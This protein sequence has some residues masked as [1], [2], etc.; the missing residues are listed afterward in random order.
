MQNE[1]II[2]KLLPAVIEEFDVNSTP[3]TNNVTRYGESL[4]NSKR[5][6][7]ENSN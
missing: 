2:S 5:I 4:K 1:S 7:L 6:P 3:N